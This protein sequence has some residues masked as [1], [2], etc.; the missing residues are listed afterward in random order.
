MQALC[1]G[2]ICRFCFN[3]DKDPFM[4]SDKIKL[5]ITA[6]P[7]ISIK[8]EEDP[9]KFDERAKRRAAGEPQH[10][11]AMKVGGQNYNK[12]AVKAALI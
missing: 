1:F 10:G 8:R 7:E 11:E 12:Q 3:R 9:Q 6:P 5:G 4:I 2:I